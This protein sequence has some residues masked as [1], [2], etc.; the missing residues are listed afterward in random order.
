[1]A[2]KPKNLNEKKTVLYSSGQRPP[3]IPWFFS[4]LQHMLL[5]LSLG[6][7]MPVSIA[8]AAGLDLRLSSSLL[9]A[10]LFSMGLPAYCRPYA[11][12]SLVQD[13]RVCPSPILPRFR[14]VF[15]PLK[16]AACRWFWV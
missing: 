4:S 14:R 10:A 3:A 12:A 13:I 9:A 1:M 6:M 15:W 8:R 11:R 5:I 2:I 16:S 7:A